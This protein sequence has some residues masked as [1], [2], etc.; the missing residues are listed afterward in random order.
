M[1]HILFFNVPP[2]QRSGV[3]KVINAIKKVIKNF[4]GVELIGVFFPR[5]SGYMYATITK[6]QDYATWEKFWTNPK[7][8]AMRQ[9][10]NAIITKQMDMFFDE[11]TY[12][13]PEPHK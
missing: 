3:P 6:Y 4:K 5:G 2:E 7:V 11:I 10:A 12:A 1:Y 8:T 13:Y 9:K